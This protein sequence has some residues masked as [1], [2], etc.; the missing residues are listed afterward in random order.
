[1]SIY[2][3]LYAAGMQELFKAAMPEPPRD[4]GIFF[5]PFMPCPAPKG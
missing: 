1:M 2:Y 4:A 3:T 5:V